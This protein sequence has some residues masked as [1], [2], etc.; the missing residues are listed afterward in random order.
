[1]NPLKVSATT[2][3]AVLEPIFEDKKQSK[4]PKAK[5]IIPKLVNYPN[6]GKVVY[7]YG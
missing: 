7:R 2:F 6:K 3:K 4:T 5:V 1:L